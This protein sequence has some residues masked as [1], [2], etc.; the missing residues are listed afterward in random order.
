MSQSERRM[1]AALPAS[2]QASKW[3]HRLKT[4]YFV[5]C[6]SISQFKHHQPLSVHCIAS[7]VHFS[8][9][10]QVC[11]IL[12]QQR[13]KF[14][15]STWFPVHLDLSY[16]PRAAHCHSGCPSVQAGQARQADSVTTLWLS[17]SEAAKQ[18]SVQ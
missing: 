6:P 10:C 11:P 8:L 9:F 12:S 15:L 3:P 2:P 18:H 7:V 5:S 4:Y 16:S 17:A 14:P 1:S 13:L